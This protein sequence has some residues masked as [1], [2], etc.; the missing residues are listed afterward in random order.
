[1]SEYKVGD[2]VTIEFEITDI[3][4]PYTACE[5]VDKNGDV[6]PSIYYFQNVA[7]D[8]YVRQH[9]PK[10]VEPAVGQKWR[11]KTYEDEY[12]TIVGVLSDYIL[13]TEEIGKRP[14]AWRREE[15]KARFQ[16]ASD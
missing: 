16:Y 1:M 5:V 8:D 11:L 12:R 2:R 3:G 13:T 4:S 6:T 10:P 7:M 15:F 14:F 9:S